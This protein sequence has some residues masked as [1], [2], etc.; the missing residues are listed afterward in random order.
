MEKVLKAQN[1]RDNSIQYSLIES[2]IQF[3]NEK[4]PTYG[5]RIESL[6]SEEKPGKNKKSEILDITTNYGQVEGLFEKVVNL[7]ITPT[8]LIDVTEDFIN[9]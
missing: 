9:S 7:E 5:I 2:E 8:Q 4:A 3:D 1:S 6:I